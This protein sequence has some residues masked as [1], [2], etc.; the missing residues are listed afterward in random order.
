MRVVERKEFLAL[1]K[2]TVYAELD[3]VDD[4]EQK[5]VT[6]THDCI[7]IKG[8]SLGEPP[9]DWFYAPLAPDVDGGDTGGSYEDSLLWDE[10]E[11]GASVKGARFG[12]RNGFFDKE[13]Y[14]LIFEREDIILM[15]DA[16]NKVLEATK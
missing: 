1:P 4:S 15:R 3:K 6:S 5:Y 13:N 10:M 11:K 2:N 16:F 7:E 14:F 8:D 12:A 9:S